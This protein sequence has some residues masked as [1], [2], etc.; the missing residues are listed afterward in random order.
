MSTALHRISSGV[1]AGLQ[2]YDEEERISEGHSRISSRVPDGVQIYKEEKTSESHSGDSIAATGF[3]DAATKQLIRKLDIRLIP[4]LSTIYLV[5]FLDRANAG[6]ARLEGLEKDLHMTGLD[7]NIALSVFFPFYV[8]VGV[9]SNM[10]IKKVCPN[11][12]LTGI[13][14]F[15]S[16]VMVCTGLVHD[17]AGFLVARCFL[18]IAEGGLYPGVVYYI[19]MWYPRNECGFRIAL[20]FSMA[21]A[22]GAFGGLFARG[23]S[24]MSGVGGKD[25]WSWIF[26]IEGLL[27]FCVGCISYW[28]IGD[29][30]NSAKFLSE[31]ERKEVMRRLT[32]DRNLLS[33]DWN[34][35]YVW[36][37]LKDWKI[38]VNMVLGF[39]LS[40][41]IYS[42][43]LFLPTIVKDMGYTNN[44]AQLMTIPPY[45]VACFF[46]VSASFFADRMK[47]RGRFILG[48]LAVG[49]IG[50]ALLVSSNKTPVQYTGAFLAA[51]GVFPTLSLLTT[52][53]GN[54]LSGSLKRGVGFGMVVGFANFGGIVAAFIYRSVDGPRFIE[55]HTIFISLLSLAFVLTALMMIFYKTENN[56]RDARDAE[57]GLTAD[58]YTPEMKLQQKDE[59]DDATFWRYTI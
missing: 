44:A 30:P 21:T 39:C 37:A 33:D 11:I 58:T 28:A 6:N 27:T 31:T 42:L 40:T 18:G 38:Y 8:A 17:Y 32:I 10:I 34:S 29:Y 54:N 47:Q 5:C 43:S 15:W 59:G 7:Y 50:S 9:P 1:F 3:D 24:E 12:W 16:I 53:V 46:T 57:Q 23:I 35:T 4:I 13:V 22:A 26:I 55:G 2:F 56:R 48:F 51:L 20:F 52:W 36:Q 25:G 19:T 49:I 45:V 14:L 41:P